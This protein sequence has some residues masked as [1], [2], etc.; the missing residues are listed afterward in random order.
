MSNDQNIDAEFAALFLNEAEAEAAPKVDE[1]AA[2]VQELVAKPES[3]K[4]ETKYKTVEGKVAIDHGPD[5]SFSNVYPLGYVALNLR[6]TRFQNKLVLW[7][8]DAEALIAWFRS[9]EADK[10]LAAAKTAGLRP[11]GVPAPSKEA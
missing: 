11:K 4:P 8:A 2:A 7:E 1:R 3:N 10:W 9:D 6:N 5:N